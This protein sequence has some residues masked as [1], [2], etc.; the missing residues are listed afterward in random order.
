MYKAIFW[1]VSMPPALPP[2]LSQVIRMMT[3]AFSVRVV[4]L[5]LR[6]M[7]CQNSLRVSFAHTSQVRDLQHSYFTHLYIIVFSGCP[8]AAFVFFPFV[9]ILAG[10]IECCPLV[11]HL[12]YV[13]M[14]SKNDGTDRR[15]DVRLLYYA[16][17]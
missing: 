8:S 4:W 7:L 5:Q 15:T 2:Q 16:Y 9:Y 14:K 11:S 12:K 1:L 3:T 6:K 17:G 13:L 10:R